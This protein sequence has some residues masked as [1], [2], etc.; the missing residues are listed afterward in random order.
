LTNDI[1]KVMAITSD[2]S[3]YIIILEIHCDLVNYTSFLLI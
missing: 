3:N 1:A 2:V